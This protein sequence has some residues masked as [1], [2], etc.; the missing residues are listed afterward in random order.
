MI[1]RIDGD[2][3]DWKIV[4]D[5]YFYG[6]DM[7][8]DVE[9]DDPKGP[10]RLNKIDPKDLDIKV[11]IGWVKG[12]NCIYFLYQAFDNYWEFDNDDLLNDVS[13]YA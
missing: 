11:C 10:M 9:R 3:S 12:M 2:P 13:K 6:T 7:L 4:P 8:L 5:E 1:P